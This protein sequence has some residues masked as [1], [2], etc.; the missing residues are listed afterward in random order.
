MYIAVHMCVYIHM[1]VY[2]QYTTFLKR[3]NLSTDGQN[4]SKDGLLG[5]KF[6]HVP[7]SVYVHIHVHTCTRP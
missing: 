1:Y 5:P 2:T 6:H 3:K 7:V 4:Y